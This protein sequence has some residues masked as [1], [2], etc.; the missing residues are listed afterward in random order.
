MAASVP[1]KVAPAAAEQVE[2][3]LR[4]IPGSYG[5]IPWLKSIKDRLD[6]FWLEGET[7]FWEK[8][9]RA[10]KSTVFRTHV[11]PSPPAFRPNP[12]VMLLD[13]RS[14]PILFDTDKVGGFG[15]G[16]GVWVWGFGFGW[17]WR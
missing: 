13:Q 11:P 10:Y 4:E 7:Q 3:P 9:R 5:R 12:V 6:F 1:P 8:R 15:I 14:F 2:L 16:F 17:R